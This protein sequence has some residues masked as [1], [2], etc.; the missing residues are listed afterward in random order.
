MRD[1]ES[2]AADADSV[3]SALVERGHR[4]DNLRRLVS[5]DQLFQIWRLRLEHPMWWI[6]TR[7]RYTTSMLAQIISELTGEPAYGSHSAIGG[8]G[9]HWFN[10][11]KQAIQPLSGPAR[12]KLA[13][14]LRRELLGRQL[15]MS[16]IP[17]EAIDV[18]VE[19]PE[20]EFDSIID[21][22]DLMKAVTAAEGVHGT[23]WA[24]AFKTMLGDL[25]PIT[26]GNLAESLVTETPHTHG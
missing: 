12:Q 19:F 2:D 11:T 17:V 3:T 5:D 20:S 24:D 4:G 14:A 9:T 18:S 10:Q 21:G 26:W 7:V 15:C 6:G 16:Q 22:A 13:A 1:W 23:D 8:V 25:D